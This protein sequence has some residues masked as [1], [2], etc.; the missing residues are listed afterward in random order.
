[1]DQ[2]QYGSIVNG[3]E[4]LVVKDWEDLWEGCG[5]RRELKYWPGVGQ[6]VGDDGVVL[7]KAKICP[8]N[9]GMKSAL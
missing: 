4:T 1:M 6:E 8:K 5:H 9:S 7:L 3:L 2:H